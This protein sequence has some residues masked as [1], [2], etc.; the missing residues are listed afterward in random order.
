MIMGVAS[1]KGMRFT[2]MPSQGCG[3]PLAVSP[4]SDVTVYIVENRSE[5]IFMTMGVGSLRRM[6][7]ITTASQ[8]YKSGRCGQGVVTVNLLSDP[9]LEC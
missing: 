3:S 8:E 1:L 7:S 5:S 6:T 9:F 2:Q 4:S